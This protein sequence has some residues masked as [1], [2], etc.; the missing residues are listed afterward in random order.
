M[1]LA[2]EG[3]LASITARRVAA[4]VGVAQGLVSHYF[5]SVDELLASTFEHAAAIDRA[6]MSAQLS[7]T[8]IDQLRTMLVL[9]GSHDRDPIA[10]LW[11]DA[12]RESARRPAVQ[13]VV[14]RAMEHDLADLG[15]IIVQGKAAGFFPAAEAHSAMRI[16]ALV[17]GFSSSAAVRAGIAGSDLDYEDVFDFVLRTSERE[18]GLSVGSLDPGES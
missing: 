16:L 9:L 15:A 3:G 10:L 6:E 7:G 13:R 14:V 8:P 17:D 11:L 12:W 4:E 1:K 18:L 2:I 5:G